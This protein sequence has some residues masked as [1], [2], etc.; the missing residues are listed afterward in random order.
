MGQYADSSFLVSCYV[1]DTNTPRAKAILSTIHAPLVF[2]DLHWLEVQNAFQLGIFRGHLSVAEGAAALANL[3]SDLRSGR[4]MRTVVTWPAVFRAAAGLSR[5]Y[6]K[7]AGTRSLD[8]LHVASARS[9]RAA[10]FLSFDTRQL[11]LAAHA[12]LKVPTTT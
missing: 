11:A 2:T 10:E 12:G 9:L 5:R 6:S 8:I 7:A 3:R 1:V 4:L